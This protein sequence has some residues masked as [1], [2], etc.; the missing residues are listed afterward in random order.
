[1]VV[2][3]GTN[4]LI[5]QGN[6]LEYQQWLGLLQELDRPARSVMISV[7]VAEVRLTESEQFGFEFLVREFVRHGYMLTYGTLGGLGVPTDTGLS[8]VLRT[9]SGDPRA[10]LNALASNNRVRVLSNPS[11]VARNG[12][13]A[14]IQVGQEVPVI[15]SQQSEANTNT[16]TGGILQT[17]QYRQVGVI[18][19]VKPV[20]HSGG[21]V[22]L[23]VQQE[24]SSA[25]ETR[26]GV[27]SSPTIATRKVET[28]LSVADGSTVLL[29]GLITRTSS[30]TDSGVPYVKDVP[31]LGSLFSN[32]S[33]STDVTEL[34]VM[35]TPYVIENDFEAGA[36]T[37]A[38]RSQFKWAQPA[39]RVSQPAAPALPAPG[40]PAA[41]ED[42]APRS[43]P[44]VLP[45]ESN[46]PGE[47]N[48]VPA[49]QSSGQGMEPRR[50]RTDTVTPNAAGI[51]RADA[52]KPR[53]PSESEGGVVTDETL[54]KEL[55]E[56]V[57][58]KK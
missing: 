1:V 44:Y 42:A 31:L 58:G 20:I 52:E 25:T 22:D 55:R 6:A 27:T 54:L 23:E 49:Q 43:R 35:I 39:P 33:D 40:A 8:A 9:Q 7:T 38:F 13:A 24:V 37:D 17:I 19:R 16:G 36:V 18:L 10:V 29:G 34:V 14:A 2:N 57:K 4:T 47:S 50:E 48:V 45:P 46:A 53:P 30:N 32:R 11:I 3:P 26:T 41:A 51:P 28:K 56:A 21:R 5:I 15:T 12:E